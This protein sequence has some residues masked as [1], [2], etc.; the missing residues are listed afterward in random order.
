MSSTHP[1]TTKS[2]WRLT[3]G[4]K[5]VPDS[6]LSCKQPWQQRRGQLPFFVWYLYRYLPYHIYSLNLIHPILKS[7]IDTQWHTLECLILAF[8]TVHVSLLCCQEGRNNLFRDFVESNG[9]TAE[10]EAKYQARL[11]EAQKAKLSGDF[12]L[13]NGCATDMAA[14]K[15]TRS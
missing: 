13:T 12:D 4:G 15:R 10:V 2:G 7:W 6:L 3:D 9:N 5:V 8:F 1:P 14:R 11:E